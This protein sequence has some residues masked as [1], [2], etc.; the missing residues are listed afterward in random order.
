MPKLKP[1]NWERSGGSGAGTE[2]TCQSQSVKGTEEPAACKCFEISEEHRC[3]SA[4]VSW[5][6]V[7]ETCG[8]RVGW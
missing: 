2:G 3:A 8:V 1:K 7:M 5:Y 6:P 4:A